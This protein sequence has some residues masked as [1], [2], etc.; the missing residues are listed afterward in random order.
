MSA[1]DRRPRRPLGA[2]RC[3]AGADG[4]LAAAVRAPGAL[5]VAARI[6]SRDI[7][8]SALRISVAKVEARCVIVFW[9]EFDMQ[10]ALPDYA[11][12]A[13]RYRSLARIDV[14]WRSARLHFRKAAHQRGW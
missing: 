13:K 6:S 12:M 2:L 1:G 7:P 11:G 9:R 3:A 14:A 4:R 10:V 5:P 8:R